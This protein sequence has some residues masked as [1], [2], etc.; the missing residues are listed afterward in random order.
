MKRA[1]AP[2]NT[3]EAVITI[4]PPSS[5]THPHRELTPQVYS[6][7]GPQLAQVNEG[8]WPPTHRSCICRRS[9]VQSGTRT[10][11]MLSWFRSRTDDS[12][13]QRLSR[14]EGIWMHQTVRPTSSLVGIQNRSGKDTRTTGCIFTDQRRSIASLINGKKAAIASTANTNR[15][16]WRQRYSCHEEC[17]AGGFR[18]QVFV[19]LGKRHVVN[20]YRGTCTATGP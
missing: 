12:S 15:L 17:P 13:S 10:H 1:R 5:R 7:H 16:G 8:S 9:I 19:G 18:R 2:R 20:S 4:T 11:R 14:N 6:V 3:T